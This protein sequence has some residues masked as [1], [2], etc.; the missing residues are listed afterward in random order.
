[1]IV[2]GRAIAS[3]IL[4]EVN[5][6]L[7]GRSTIVRAVVVRPSPATQSYLRIKKS[8]AEEGGMTLEVV[9]LRDEA[10]EEEIIEA[11]KAP[12]GD[13]V[14][15]QLPIPEHLNW[16]RVLNE[17]PLTQDADVLSEAAYARFMDNEPGALVPPVAAGIVEIL[18]R[19]GVDVKGKKTTVVGKGKLVGLPT[20]TVLERMGAQV[21]FVIKETPEE[22]KL[23][24]LKEADMVISGAGAA[25]IIR[26]DMLKEGVILVDAGTSGS[27]GGVAGDMHPD[28]AE[29]ASLFTPV[30]GG[31]GP[32]AVSCL[33]KNTASLLRGRGELA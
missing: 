24:L 3:A 8:R 18:T 12:G 26:P 5:A 14:I 9:K 23:A 6:S 21:T 13:A 1:M 32:V 16:Q 22:E 31:V 10:T 19:S 17:I 15:V 27:G 4:S 7:G 28:C 29:K 30:P 25:H 11:V 33:F 2:D 20:G